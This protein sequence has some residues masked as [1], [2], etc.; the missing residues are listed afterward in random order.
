MQ[1]HLF[2]KNENGQGL[3]EYLL[4]VALMG[5]ATIAIVR[6][7]NQ[8]VSAK[9]AQVTYAIQGGSKKRIKVAP[10]QESHTKKKD[11]SDFFNG[12]ATQ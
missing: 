5:V 2:H 11:M 6:T 9:F 8:T 1:K 4:L 12:V 10:V 3:I 7:L